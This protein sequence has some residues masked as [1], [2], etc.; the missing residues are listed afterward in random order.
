MAVVP[1]G[2]LYSLSAGRPE[3]SLDGGVSL[4][5]GAVC[6]RRNAPLG[7]PGAPPPR[8][9][10]FLPAAQQGRPGSGPQPAPATGR[11]PA[12]TGGW[13]SPEVPPR[14]AQK[15]GGGVTSATPPAPGVPSSSQQLGGS[16]APEAE[17]KEGPPWPSPSFW[18]HPPDFGGASSPGGQARSAHQPCW[19]P[20][21]A[22][23]VPSSTRGVPA[24][25]GTA[26]AWGGTLQNTPPPRYT[27]SLSLGQNRGVLTGWR[28][29]LPGKR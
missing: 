2:S 20:N 4:A 9:N 3:T 12:G 23:L 21:W 14:D 27:G 17:T 5:E 26:L 24:E 11:P 1:R 6:H 29:P 28:C 18:G 8:V 22:I 16:Q 19:A 10:S 15:A 25:W 7:R 13:S